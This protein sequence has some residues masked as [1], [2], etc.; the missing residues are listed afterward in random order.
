DG[1][2]RWSL[3]G[4]PR[5]TPIGWVLRRC[6]IDELP[7]LVNV[8]IGDM[9][10][11][12]P[13]PERPELIPQLVRALPEY[14][15]RL[16]VRPGITGLAQVQQPPDENLYTVR[17]KLN[18]DLCYVERMNLW[19]DVRLILATAL[20]CLGF[21]FVAIGRILNLPDPNGDLGNEFVMSKSDRA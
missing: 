5:I 21:S 2:A 6:H 13:R 19:L 1:V 14:R 3:P 4:D 20:K 11:I 7:Q 8:M 16:F 12:G 15:N 9:S 10:L 17:R 18:F